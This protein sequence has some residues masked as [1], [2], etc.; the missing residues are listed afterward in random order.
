MSPI[1]GVFTNPALEAAMS[2]RFTPK[3]PMS[4]IGQN[5]VS[6]VSWFFILHS[7]FVIGVAVAASAL[8]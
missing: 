2:Y 5:I 4:H 6:A 7:F 1:A 3:L 8:H